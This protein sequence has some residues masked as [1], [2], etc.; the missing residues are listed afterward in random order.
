MK[1]CKNEEMKRIVHTITLLLCVF[2]LQAQESDDY[3]PFIEDGKVWVSHQN[4]PLN[5]YRGASIRYDYFDG[6]T[7]VCEKNCKRWIQEYRAADGQTILYQFVISAYEENRRVYFFFSGDNEAHLLFDYGAIS[8]DT[9][10]VSVPYTPLWEIRDQIK[11]SEVMY[12][13]LFQDT[14]TILSRG[15]KTVG[16]REQRVINYKSTSPIRKLSKYLMEG[17]GSIYTPDWVMSYPEGPNASRFP[18][19]QLACCYVGDEILYYDQEIVDS[20]R[21]SLPTS[22]RTIKKENPSKPVN[23]YDLTGRR[24]SVPSPSSVRSV[25]PKGVYIEDGKKRVRK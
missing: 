24:L 8:G 3:R 1:K 14:L 7:L 2:S 13:G 6:D 15:M 9:L 20:Y 22:I 4:I 23:C 12:K 10:T 18:S 17:V 21:I 5:P 25:L 16:G 11:D 19:A